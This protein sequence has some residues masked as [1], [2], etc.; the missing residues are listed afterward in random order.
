M[1]NTH[2]LKFSAGFTLL[3]CAALASGAQKFLDYP[4][5]QP[6]DYQLSAQQGDV[7][8]ALEPVDSVEDQQT[9]FHTSLTPSGFL[10]VL[11]VVHNRSRS[12]SLL[13]DKQNISYGFGET[14]KPAPKENSAGQ[15]V[16]IAS[17]GFI[18][19][20]GPF[21]ASGLAKDA[22]EIKQ[23][24]MLRELQSGT[25]SP[26]ETV[27]GFLYVP[28]PKKGPRPKIHIRFPITWTGSDATS[29]LQI[30]F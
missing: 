22:S 20:I 19:F 2:V 13:L 30:E 11:V 28:I 5:R 23:N 14:D 27:H 29:V 12:D 15:K 16:A 9:Y 4:V 8:I 17:T 7:S 1:L 10:P 6:N 26:D 24:L 3:T 25:V 21:V 18:P